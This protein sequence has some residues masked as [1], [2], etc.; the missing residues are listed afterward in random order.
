LYINTDDIKAKRNCF[1]LEASQ[2]AER[3]RELRLA[4]RRSFA[5]VTVLSTDRNLDLLSRSK[6]AR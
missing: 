3:L 1:D 6:D 5:F 4:E 2:E